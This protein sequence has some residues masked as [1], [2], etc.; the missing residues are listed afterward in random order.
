MAVRRGGYPAPA[1]AQKVAT[2]PAWDESRGGGSRMNWHIRA[3]PARTAPADVG[4][5]G[6]CAHHPQAGA[7]PAACITMLQQ[8][9]DEYYARFRV[10]E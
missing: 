1:A 2:L 3:Q 6:D 4:L 7:S 9:L 5:R 8:E 10:S